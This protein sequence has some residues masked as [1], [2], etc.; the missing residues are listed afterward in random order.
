[1]NEKR[2]TEETSMTS[3]CSLTAAKLK[4]MEKKS[5]FDSPASEFA[6]MWIGLRQFTRYLFGNV[7]N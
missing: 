1:M 3:P 5:K 4:V 6:D 2:I 7:V